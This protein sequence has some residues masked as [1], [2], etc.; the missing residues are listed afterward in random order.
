MAKTIK[1]FKRKLHKQKKE[2]LVLDL[3]T[4]VA[5]LAQET[6]DNVGENPA[7]GQINSISGTQTSALGIPLGTPENASAS[8]LSAASGNIVQPEPIFESSPRESSPLLPLYTKVKSHSA[9]NDLNTKSLS[10]ATGTDPISTVSVFGDVVE[11]PNVAGPPRRR[12]L[13]FFVP[14]TLLAIL[15]VAVQWM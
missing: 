1:K 7:P 11:H 4:D 10:S 2:D 12:M 5:R 3:L 15:L 14:L 8:L 6:V 13:L 9:L